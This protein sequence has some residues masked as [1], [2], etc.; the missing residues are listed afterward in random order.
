MLF[1][2]K[3]KNMNVKIPFYIRL[4][5]LLLG[6]VLFFFI[7]IQAKSVFVPLLISLL[8]AILISSFTSWLESK[9]IP[10]SLAVLISVL[11]IVVLLSGLMFFF[12]NQLTNLSKDLS[13]LE[14]RLGEL[15]TTINSFLMEKFNLQFPLSGEK[16]R[17]TIFK[18]LSEN[19]S[20][21]TQ[22]VVATAGT[23]AMVLLIPIYVFFLLFYRHFLVS[24]VKKAFS[25]QSEEKVNSVVFKIKDVVHN[26]I[27]GMLIVILILSVLYSIAFLSL[28][29]DFAI[30]FAVFAAFL[31][32]IP[33]VGPWIGTILP[34]VYALLT[35]DS[36]WYPAGVVMVTYIIQLL[37]GNFITPKIVG[38]KVS[39]NPLMTI[40][41]LFIGGYIW[42]IAGMILFIPGMA[43]LKVIFDEIDSMKPYGF[44]LGEVDEKY[45]VKRSRLRQ[46]ISKPKDEK[47]D[48]E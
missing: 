14:T 28:G 17:Q 35:K 7:M 26:Y 31:N 25:N 10:K 8:L 32:I 43:I 11:V 33:F 1:S 9:K 38:S 27:K 6:I 22:G 47:K 13:S 19:M 30:L 46:T 3:K 23:L 21:I 15:T 16:F 41:A 18:Q 39:M 2:V 29:I 44:L 24:F 20:A 45:T 12:F 36:L 4:T 42:G 5:Y 34:M 40:L 37:E 48:G